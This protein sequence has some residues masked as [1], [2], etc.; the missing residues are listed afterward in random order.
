VN[1]IKYP[2]APQ[3]L[4]HGRGCC[5][6]SLSARTGTVT[7]RQLNTVGGVKDNRE[8]E[9]FHDGDT[10]E[11]HHKIIVPEEC[12]LSVSMIFLFPLDST[13]LRLLK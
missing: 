1:L 13:F 9:A 4:L 11:V 8:S 5:L 2:L 10:P 6:F 7:T 12:A 3:P